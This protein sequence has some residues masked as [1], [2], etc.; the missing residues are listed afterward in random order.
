MPSAGQKSDLA[1]S[2]LPSRGPQSKGDVVR[3]GCHTLTLSGAQKRAEL[4]SN[5]CILRDPKSKGDKIRIAY[6]NPT[7]SGPKRGWNCYVT[8]AFSGVSHQARGENQKWL[9]HPCLPRGPHSKGDIIRIGCLTPTLS[10][11]Q[12]RA[13]LLSNPCI[14]GGHQS[15]GDKITMGCH[16]PTLL[17]A[18]NRGELLSNR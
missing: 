17:G 2:P 14:L 1:S 8:P 5:P 18:Q 3:I 12:K 6:L 15:K 7:V 10:G 13:K 4:L 9:S 16:T 11:A